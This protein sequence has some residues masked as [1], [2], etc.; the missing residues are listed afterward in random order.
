MSNR[1]YIDGYQVFGNYEMFSRTEKAL[2]KQGAQWTDDGTFSKIKIT[3]IESLLNAIELDSL[4]YLK[5]FL[6]QEKYDF[7]T[8]KQIPQRNFNDL[9][10]SDF[11]CSRR[12]NT[13]LK[14]ICFTKKGAPRPHSYR[15]LADFLDEKRI[16]TAYNV[17]TH[18]KS[19]CEYKDGKLVIKP[20]RTIYAWMS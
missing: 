8:H 3:D 18:I 9:E 16:F 13:Y 10:D 5:D 11:L 19:K 2:T 6:C 15:M 12:Y 14:D 17:W 20:H 7:E 1:F 4:Y